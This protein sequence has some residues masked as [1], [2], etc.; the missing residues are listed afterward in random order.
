VADGPGKPRHLGP[1]GASRLM[2]QLGETP[3]PTVDPGARDSTRHIIGHEKAQ[4]TRWRARSSKR[5]M[6]ARKTS[7]VAQI[8]CA[9]VARTCSQSPLIAAEPCSDHPRRSAPFTENLISIGAPEWFVLLPMKVTQGRIIARG[10]TNRCPN[11]GGKTLFKEGARFELNKTCPACGL[12]IEKEEG[13]FLGAMSLNYGIT[14]IG[15]LAPITV[16]WYKGVLNNTAAAALG[17]A[18]A[19]VVP[20]ALYRSSRSWQLMLYYTFLPQHLPANRRES[21]EED[22][23]GFA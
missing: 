15:F 2:K 5:A 12:K 19:F 16:L 18:V 10:L 1:I 20:V 9:F 13:F 23:N 14:C 22:G 21:G 8:L 11:C 7:V 3:R 4:E 6:D 17:L